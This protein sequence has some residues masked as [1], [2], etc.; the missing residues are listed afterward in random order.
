MSSFE[1]PPT[2]PPEENPE[3]RQTTSPHT[4]SYGDKRYNVD[5]SQLLPGVEI[6]DDGIF[7]IIS[8]QQEGWGYIKVA[9]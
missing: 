8:K 7:E 5:K 4:A 9:H 1:R 6:V 2:L 3:P